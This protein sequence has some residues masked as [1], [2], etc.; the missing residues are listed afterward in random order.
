MKEMRQY[1]GGEDF[2]FGTC[3]KVKNSAEK[4][5]GKGGGH[6]FCVFVFVFVSV[7]APAYVFAVLFAFTFAFTRTLG[8]LPEY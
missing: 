1:S 7:F 3:K 2:L 8:V 4:E 6:I 5:F